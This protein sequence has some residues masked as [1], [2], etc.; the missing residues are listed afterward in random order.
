MPADIASTIRDLS[1]T[2]AVL[3][4][5]LSGMP[6]S[7][8][9]ANEG[10]D[11]WSPRTVIVHLIHGEHA[12]WIPRIRMILEFG[13]VQT[14]VPFDRMGYAPGGH[15]SSLDELLEEFSWAR[16]QSLES[17]IKLDLQESQLHLKGCHQ[18][19]GEVTMSQLLATWVV[20]DLSHLSQISRVIAHQSRH[21]V[22]PWVE[23]LGILRP[24]LT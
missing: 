16:A 9:D 14:F 18:A 8:A 23:Y 22:G 13:T 4:A 15:N 2:P 17:L 19:L 1:R 3:N 24:R 7:L 5:L 10:A 21:A 11:T 12:D 6:E 20:H